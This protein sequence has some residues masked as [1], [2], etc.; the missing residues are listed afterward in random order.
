[1]TTLAVHP[2][3]ASRFNLTT[4]RQDVCTPPN[5]LPERASDHKRSVLEWEH[6]HSHGSGGSVRQ[7]V[8][9]PDRGPNH[10]RQIAWAR[11]CRHSQ[12]SARKQRT[13][14]PWEVCAMLHVLSTE[15]QG[16][17]SWGTNCRNLR[18]WSNGHLAKIAV[19][20]KGTK[21]RLTHDLRR[22][23]ANA[24]VTFRETVVSRV[25]DLTSGIMELLQSQASGDGVEFVTLDFR[26]V[27]TPTRNAQFQLELRWTV[28]SLIAP[29]CEGLDQGHLC[30]VEWLRGSCEAPKRAWELAEDQHSCQTNCFC[31]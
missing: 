26:D 17:N 6:R 22:N 29:C 9:R 1:M 28:S 27:C 8:E 30:G 19:V 13:S 15:F 12:R 2:P 14:T 5:T 11:V 20:V 7:G 23:G 21:V 24:R 31:R 4:I 10:R 25:K 16:G 18:S 3:T